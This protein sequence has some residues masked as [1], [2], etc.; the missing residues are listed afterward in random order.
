M[1]IYL[2]PDDIKAYNVIFL[3]SLQV[4]DE[5]GLQSAIQRP[6]MA[7][8]YQGA[9][10]ALQSALLIEGIALAH[11]FVDANKRTA[12]MAGLVFLDLNGFILHYQQGMTRDELGDYLL[13]IV[14][15]QR[16]AD[17][18]AQ[19]IRQHMTQKP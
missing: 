19:W 15:H 18:F 7:A 14:M 6:Q 4:R 2:T 5:S 8:Y 12:A 10:M 9:D 1:T 17:Q 16:T 11:P 3:G 13:A